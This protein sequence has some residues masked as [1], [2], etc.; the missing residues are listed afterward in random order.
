MDLTVDFT[1]SLELEEL[2]ERISSVFT[3][4]DVSFFDL[5]ANALKGENGLSLK[6]IAGSVR[7]AFRAEAAD[8]KMIFAS[9][10][11]LGIFSAVFAQFGQ[12][13]ESRQVADIS[14]DIVFLLMVMILLKIMQ[15]GMDITQ[16]SL[17]TIADFSKLL[18][19]TYCL[20]VG[21]AAG[22][23]TAVAFYELALIVIYLIENL[24]LVAVVPMIYV[25]TLLSVM[26]GISPDGRLDG[27][28]AFTKKGIGFVLKC[29]ITVISGIGL[30]QGM[31]TPVVDSVST[32]ALQKLV[33]VI[34]AIGGFV[35]T[36]TDVVYGSAVLIKNA[37]GVAGILLLLLLCAMPL[38]KLL[39]LALALKAAA[40]I[41]G[42]VADARMSRCVEQVS[43]GSVL[44]FRTTACAMALLIVTIAVISVTTNRGF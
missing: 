15:K 10:L 9:I 2:S 22:S 3:Q 26:S 6:W 11:I 41:S 16:E 12:L 17:V 13:F 44:L 27:I 43:E 14:Y 19:P 38:L 35:N 24:L 23:A 18:V 34:P 40:A 39:L 4:T 36:A 7:E 33:S 30:L 28:L 21:F 32:G 8:Y 1:R 25:Y 29:C 20:S 37:V 42:V 31:I 5:I